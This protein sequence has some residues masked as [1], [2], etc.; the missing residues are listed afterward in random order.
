MGSEDRVKQCLGDCVCSEAYSVRGLTDPRCVWCNY[1][2]GVTELVRRLEAALRTVA[3]G[4]CEYIEYG[5]KHNL[6]CRELWPNN[7]DEWCMS[8]MCAKV[9][10]VI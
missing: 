7:E 3:S 9:L 2:E 6:E 8:C 10:E 5:L 1:G 4:L